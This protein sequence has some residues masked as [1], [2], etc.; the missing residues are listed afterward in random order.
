MPAWALLAV[1]RVPQVVK[2][3]HGNRTLDRKPHFG[4]GPSV[5][6]L[7]GFTTWGVSF[8]NKTWLS[9]GSF[10]YLQQVKDIRGSRPKLRARNLHQ[11]LR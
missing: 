4:Y 6:E 10:I 8:K 2:P 3:H 11:I 7:K 5:I 1:W 9:L